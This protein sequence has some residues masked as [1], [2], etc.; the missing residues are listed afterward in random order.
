MGEGWNTSYTPWALSLTATVMPDSYR[1]CLPFY[2]ENGLRPEQTSSPC[3]SANLT[4]RYHSF[5]LIFLRATS[6]LKKRRVINPACDH[7]RYISSNDTHLD[8]S[9]PY[10]LAY[11]T[12]SN[13][14]VPDLL[15]PVTSAYSHL[16][17]SYAVKPPYVNLSFGKEALRWSLINLH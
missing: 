6:S 11:N 3:S 16:F 8:S 1:L 12:S 2:D 7:P 10:D 15:A 5:L 13:A 17:F 4:E 14:R 9:L